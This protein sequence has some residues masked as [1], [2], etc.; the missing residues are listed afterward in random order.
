MAVTPTSETTI[1]P[2]DIAA[3]SAA[4][5]PALL[6][7]VGD[8]TKFKQA[9]LRLLTYTLARDIHT[10]RQ[11]DW[12][13][14]TAM[15]VRENVLA[16]LIVTQGVHNN[17]NVRRLYYFSLEYLMGRLMENSLYNSGQFEVAVSALKELG[18][19]FEDIREQEVDMGLG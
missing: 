4:I 6:P 16:R 3:A 12:W 13:I 7:S 10:A 19:K 14:A 18:I 11:R 15:A 17:Q 1:T 8:T 5:D 9:F 2:K